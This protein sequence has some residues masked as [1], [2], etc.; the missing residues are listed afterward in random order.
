MKQFKTIAAVIAVVL[1][2]IIYLFIPNKIVVTKDLI[3]PQSSAGV[4]R[5]LMNIQYWDKWMPYKSIEGHSFLLEGG[6]LE[7]LESFLSSAKTIFKIEEFSTPV[8]F[9]AV[10]SGK[11]SSLIRYEAVIDN[12][13]VSPIQRIQDYW[14]S[15]KVKAQMNIVIEAAGKNYATTK[16]IYGFDITQDHVKDSVLATTH[17]IFADTPSLVQLYKMIHE[18]EAHVQKNNGTIHGDP[19]V[20]IT[21][22]SE[23]EVFAQ[24]A[25]PL[26][27]SIPE[28][29]DIQIKKMVLGNILTVKV[30][31]N[32]NKVAHAFEETQNYMH[33]RSK[34]SPAIPF[35][36]YNTNRL[37]E[38][39]PKKW[40]S[41]IYYPVY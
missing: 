29:N 17:K 37:Q 7:V 36:V 30:V 38:A 8:T 27:K 31:G 4:T 35:V 10:A 34:S 2:F 41:T 33:D 9:S 32:G 20:N 5:G 3:V 14:V 40:V 6:S 24:V 26:A 21:R 1:F 18:L 16:G 11:D 23:K 39:D 19:M 28:A 15:K 22:L 13:H 12:R 25:Y